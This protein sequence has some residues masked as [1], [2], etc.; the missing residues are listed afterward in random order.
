MGRRICSR[1]EEEIRDLFRLPGWLRRF[2]K[3]R[4]LYFDW[5][6]R[7]TIELGMLNGGTQPRDESLVLL[8]AAALSEDE[9]FAGH[10]RRRRASFLADDDNWSQVYRAGGATILEAY[11]D[12][13]DTGS[14]P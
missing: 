6:R 10:V 8:L 12:A 13:V 1:A 3:R 14:W 7:A 4:D 5:C 2:D 11:L 9:S